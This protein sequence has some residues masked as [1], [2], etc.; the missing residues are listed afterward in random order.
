MIDNPEYAA[1]VSDKI[2]SERLLE[3]VN[4][5]EG[6]TR[7]I[8]QIKAAWR[9]VVQHVKRNVENNKHLDEY[10][11]MVHEAIIKRDKFRGATNDSNASPCT[12]KFIANKKHKMNPNNSCISPAEEASEADYPSSEGTEHLEETLDY[13]DCC[14]ET[15][16]QPRLHVPPKSVKPLDKESVTKRIESYRKMQD[17]AFEIMEQEKESQIH[18]PTNATT[19]SG[20][21]VP[22]S[23]A[24]EKEI[25]KVLDVE[26]QDMVKQVQE[27]SDQLKEKMLST[28]RSKLNDGRK[29]ILKWVNTEFLEVSDRLDD[30]KES[31]ESQCSSANDVV[32]VASVE[33]KEVQDLMN[34]AA[35]KALTEFYIP[36]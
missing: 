3:M 27:C 5:L 34:N 8:E 11:T 32:S 18:T 25:N 26:Q 9:G 24:F 22:I 12:S 33:T 31:I 2:H 6:P 20:C 7:S 4:S 28:V 21:Q 30:F 23:V 16:S 36:T 17:R 13:S 15:Q 29:C 19:K 14:S 10:H 35:G 1:D